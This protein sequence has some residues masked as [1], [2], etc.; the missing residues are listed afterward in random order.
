MSSQDIKAVGFSFIECNFS[1]LKIKPFCTLF[2]EIKLWQVQVTGYWCVVSVYR[3]ELCIMLKGFN[4]LVNV[5][6]FTLHSISLFNVLEF[7]E[8]DSKV[9]LLNCDPVWIILC[10]CQLNNTMNT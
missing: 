7:S 10:S 9:I 4:T 6:S 1:D 5:L 8:L 2:K 3:F